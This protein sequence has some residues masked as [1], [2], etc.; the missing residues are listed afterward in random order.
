MAKLG[1][2]LVLAA[3][4]LV[5]TV[6]PVHATAPQIPLAQGRIA[7]LLPVISAVHRCGLREL[8]IGKAWDGRSALFIDGDS[9]PRAR[10]CATAWISK[11]HRKLALTPRW[12]GDDYSR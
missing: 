11:S 9:S 12:P 1:P 6:T 5:V 3:A 4:T 8:R 10:A 2:K 7:A